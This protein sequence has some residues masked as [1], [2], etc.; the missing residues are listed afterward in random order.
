[1]ASFR[2]RL[3]IG[4]QPLFE[5]VAAATTIDKVL[6][7]KNVNAETS[8]EIRDLCKEHQIPL[9]FVPIEKLNSFTKINHQGIIAFAALVSYL[10]LQEI[11]DLTISKG[12]V[13]FFMILDG[14]T[15]VRN[16]GAIARTALCC[17]V[18]AIII[19]D[20]GVGALNEEA[21]KSSAG[22]LEHLQIC[23][24]NSIMKAID[25][26]HT[27]GIKVYAS[28]MKA[29]NKVFDINFKEPCCVVM[30]GEERGIFSG[31]IKICD[32]I[33]NIPM[34]TKFESLNVSVAAG[35]IMYEAMLQRI[36]N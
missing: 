5:A 4:K 36:K 21:M 13:P 25:E 22:A 35:M 16:I 12:E 1:M 29:S 11:I 2:N 15:D 24:V 3:I 27:N 34:V 19:P 20:K 7:S 33:F 26:L 8:T 32:E 14:V 18:Q 28:E 10:P 6:I 31:V 17:G 30:G 9:Q 23:R